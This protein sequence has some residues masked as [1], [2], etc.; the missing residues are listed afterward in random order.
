MNYFFLKNVCMI[1][2]S[3]VIFMINCFLFL[4]IFYVIK[5]FY[6]KLGCICIIYLWGFFYV[7][8][9]FWIYGKDIKCIN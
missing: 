9:V 5:Y 6:W 7:E 3:L 2:R 4:G 8:N 1:S